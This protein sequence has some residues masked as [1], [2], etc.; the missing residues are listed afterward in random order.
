MTASAILIADDHIA[1]REGLKHIL[2]R[3]A[4]LAVSGE[5]ATLEE[6]LTELERRTFDLLLLDLSLPGTATE[7]MLTK[8]KSIA[9]ALPILVYTMYP[10]DRAA[11]R[12]LLEGVS[13]YV[14]KDSSPDTLV[15]A[16]RRVLGGRR[17]ISA[18]L[19][20]EL[21]AAAE[22]RPAH[23]AL[24]DREMQVLV[25]MTNGKSLKEIAT[26]LD[27]SLKTVSTYRRR[28][29]EKLGL[30]TNADL[31]RYAIIHRLRL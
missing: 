25:H 1:V 8:I 31:I 29:I 30:R 20:E 22:E 23:D 24:S 12:L 7:T 28:T 15:H 13:G 6:L 21:A 9:P 27:V 18:T 14:T 2:G 5:A 11:A 17:Y 16:V 10:E 26:M 19:A 4:D 3:H